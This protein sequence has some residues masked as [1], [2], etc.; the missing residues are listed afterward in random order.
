[1]S[2][3]Q[4]HS[5]TPGV[6]LLVVLESF[7]YDNL[8]DV[9]S[10]V[11][12]KAA[13]FGELSSQGEE[14]SAENA[15]AFGVADIGKGERQVPQAHAAQTPVQQVNHLRDADAKGVSQRSRQASHDLDEWPSCRVFEFAPHEES[16]VGDDPDSHFNSDPPSPTSAAISPRPAPT[17]QESKGMDEQPEAVPLPQSGQP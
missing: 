15:L 10:G 5:L 14:F 6:R 13:D 4:Q 9:F 3:K 2:G 1:M 16:G 11:F 12:G 7:V 17:G 8:V